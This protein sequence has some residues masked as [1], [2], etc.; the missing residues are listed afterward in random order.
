MPWGRVGGGCLRAAA[1]RSCAPGMHHHQLMHVMWF[2]CA[3]ELRGASFTYLT[4]RRQLP[5]QIDM[6]K[7]GRGRYWREMGIHEWRG[8]IGGRRKPSRNQGIRA[9]QE[10]NT[11]DAFQPAA[12]GHVVVE[13]VES[14]GIKQARSGVQRLREERKREMGQG[15]G[16]R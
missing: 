12:R 11:I 15:L 6:G 9:R 3:G 4:C 1:A 10:N 2:G 14:R 8:E 5:P 16:I 13:V 7:E